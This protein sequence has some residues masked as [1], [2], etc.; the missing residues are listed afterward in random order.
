MPT[1]AQMP[2]QMP[3]APAAAAA[4]RGFVPSGAE[5]LQVTVFGVQN[6][7]GIT[8]PTVKVEVAG[9]HNFQL[10]TSVIQGQSLNPKSTI[11]YVRPGDGLVFSVVQGDQ[12]FGQAAVNSEDFFPQGFE[13]DVVVG[14]NNETVAVKLAVLA[15]GQI[16]ALPP[17]VVKSTAATA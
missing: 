4:P 8:N 12:L 14:T 15:D 5:A 10:D 13:G 7:A 16:Q 6:I 1:V 9:K 2:A 3:T 11:T 17:V